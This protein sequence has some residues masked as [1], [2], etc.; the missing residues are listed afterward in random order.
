MEEVSFKALTYWTYEHPI[1]THCYQGSLA[2]TAN[3][4]DSTLDTPDTWDH[5]SCFRSN[6]Q[7]V[8]AFGRRLSNE[9]DET[10]SSS[11][12]GRACRYRETSE[13]SKQR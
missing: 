1:T 8:I 13:V 9:I 12:H 2:E 5:W 7:R 10:G 6:D 4:A 11:V 3:F